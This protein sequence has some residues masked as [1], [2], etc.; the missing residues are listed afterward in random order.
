MRVALVH[1]WLLGSRGGEKVLEAIC[2]IFPEAD[3]FT[4]FYDPERVSPLI[5]SKNVRT[6]F[7]N[8]LKRFHRGLLPLMPLA[9]EAFD[10]RAYDLVISSESGPAKGVLT[11][12][13]SRHLCY[14][15]TP[16]RYLWE[17]YPAYLNEF[18][19]AKLFRAL[20]APVASYLRTWDYSTAARVDHF[21]ANSWN[22][23]RRIWKTYRRKAKVVHPPVA[24]DSFRHNRSEGYFLLVGEMV[25]Y[26]RLDYAIRTFAHSGRKLKVVGDGPEYGALKKLAAANVEFCGRVSGEDLREL[27]ARS[28]ALVVPGIEDF[29]MTMVE[30]LASGK[31][32]VALGCGGAL[33][34]VGE[35]CG[36]LYDDSSE[37]GLSEALR[38]F[39]RLEPS[40]NPLYLR[41]AAADFSEPVFARKFSAALAGM[42]KSGADVAGVEAEFTTSLQV[43]HDTRNV[44]PL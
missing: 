30:S 37:A 8:P 21:V 43:P 32:V 38:T 20:M 36:V 44:R 4:L 6:S 35:K 12:S 10:L 29:G 28:A 1:Y 15:H 25:P 34:I 2:R 14:C 39:D 18:G 11:S 27:Y 33:E 5:R 9:L 7:L 26:K 23:R 31:P 24:V 40:F 22:V 19:R 17:L 3:I 16:M 42:M 41:T 13:T